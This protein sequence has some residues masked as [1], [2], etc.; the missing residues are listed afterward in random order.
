M[1]LTDEERSGL[2]SRHTRHQISVMVFDESA[3]YPIS[4]IFNYFSHL[5][6]VLA[7]A[8]TLGFLR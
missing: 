7:L 6:T 8:D 2:F 1:K 3:A 5:L 4:D